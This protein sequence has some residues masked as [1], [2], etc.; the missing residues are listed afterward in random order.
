MQLR[1]FK[2]KEEGSLDEFIEL[3]DREVDFVE[4]DGVKYPAKYLGKGGFAATMRI[5]VQGRSLVIKMHYG[6]GSETSIN[7][8]RE[9]EVHNQVQLRTGLG[10]IAAFDDA[11]M[12]KVVSINND[13]LKLELIPFT[14]EPIGEDIFA[15]IQDFD[16]GQQMTTW[17]PLDVDDLLEVFDDYAIDE[18]RKCGVA[19]SDRNPNNIFV[20]KA[21]PEAK[22]HKKRRRIT[23]ID[24]GT[25]SLV[26]FNVITLF[27]II[28]NP[29][30]FRN[31]RERLVFLCEVFS[32]L[33]YDRSM[34]YNEIP[35]FITTEEIIKYSRFLLLALS[36]SAVP[37]SGYLESPSYEDYAKSLS[38]DELDQ[39]LDRFEAVMQVFLPAEK[40]GELNAVLAYVSFSTVMGENL[41]KSDVDIDWNDVVGKDR[42]SLIDAMYLKEDAIFGHALAPCPTGLVGK[43]N[44]R[45]FEMVAMSGNYQMMWVLFTKIAPGLLPIDMKLLETVH[46]GDPAVA[47]AVMGYNL[48]EFLVSFEQFFDHIKASNSVLREGYDDV[49][50]EV[51]EFF[52]TFFTAFYATEILE[53]IDL[54]D[55]YRS[56]FG[57]IQNLKNILQKAKVQPEVTAEV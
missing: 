23:H 25:S 24:F 2:E 38:D 56:A 30:I 53:S 35:G 49:L 42:E 13:T 5:E 36:K 27:R 55:E 45:D 39:R 18:F 1:R 3:L 28:R 22:E 14:P 11:W 6:A 7:I 34:P 48:P 31:K 50:Q 44:M 40:Q 12:F 15:T 19:D 54:R 26:K 17:M 57:L 8:A 21:N 4:F 33:A 10:S 16:P 47:I 43:L 29:S 51:Y 46:K 32:S 20:R 9:S 52:I 41:K 37:R